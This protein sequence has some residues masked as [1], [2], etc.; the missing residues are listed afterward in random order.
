MCERAH[1]GRFDDTV[2]EYD[3]AACCGYDGRLWTRQY[4]ASVTRMLRWMKAIHMVHV[5][6]SHPGA[7]GIVMEQGTLMEMAQELWGKVS[8]P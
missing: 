8:R 4:D 1:H 2:L 7:I 3:C 6:I 5:A